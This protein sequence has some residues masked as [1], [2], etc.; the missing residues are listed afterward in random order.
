LADT[1]GDNEKQNVQ[2]SVLIKNA[3]TDAKVGNKTSFVSLLD[4]LRD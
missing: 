4:Y 2:I 1:N 3:L